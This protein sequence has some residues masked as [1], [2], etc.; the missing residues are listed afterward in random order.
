MT[1]PPP[2]TG[3]HVDYYDSNGVATAVPA[4]VVSI[5]V[6]LLAQS[7]KQVRGAGGTLANRTDSVSFFA[8]LRN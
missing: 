1:G 6:T 7:F 8:H 4:Q 2:A 5:K 3:L